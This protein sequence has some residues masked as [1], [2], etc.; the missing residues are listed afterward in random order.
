MK[1]AL[2]IA[3]LATP[4]APDIQAVLDEFRDSQDVPGISAVVIRD[5]EVIF[6]GATGVADIETARSM[7]ANTVLYM[8]SLSKVLTAILTLQLVESGQLSLDDPVDGIAADPTGN[9]S[10][11]NVGHLLT[12]SSGLVR[13][14]NFNYW[15]TAD[16]P[17]ATSLSGYLANTTL[18]SAPGAALH[19]SNIGYAALGRI[20]EK[21]SDQTYSDALR[22]RLLEPLGMTV[23][24]V[25]GP[26]D[27]ISNGYT[28]PGRIIPSAERPFAGVGERVGSRNVRMY[29]NARAMS[30][31]FGVYSSASDLGR[32]ARFL[33][34]NGDDSVLSKSMRAR[35]RELQPSGWGLGLKVQTYQGRLVAR[36]DGW[37]AAHRSHMLLDVE[38]GIAVIVMANSD[39]ASP[40]RI[41]EGLFEAAIGYK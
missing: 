36:H 26:S 41:A 14:G 33:L 5:N 32:L 6:S 2:L 17:D 23:S 37:F 19:Y 30:P 34:G 24:G 31:A 10:A 1:I 11:I 8:G 35:M 40:R 38:N 21:A 22:T 16:F 15:F 13:E 20:I 25:P 29:H 39:S 7:T 18:R 28:P 12:H 27:D 9:A 4:E 3:A